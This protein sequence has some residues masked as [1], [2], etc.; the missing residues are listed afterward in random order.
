MLLAQTFFGC[1][2]NINY[3]RASSPT[4]TVFR[5]NTNQSHAYED[6]SA[7]RSKPFYL[8]YQ[9]AATK[10]IAHTPFSA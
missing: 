4:R 3:S 10:L 7:K 8:D 9:L 6:V 2:V 1:I 5:L